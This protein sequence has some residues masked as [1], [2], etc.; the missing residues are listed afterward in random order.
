MIVPAPNIEGREGMLKCA[1]Q[2]D[3][4]WIKVPLMYFIE[5]DFVYSY[6]LNN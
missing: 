3:G 6:T 5:D 2:L 4:Q 1:I